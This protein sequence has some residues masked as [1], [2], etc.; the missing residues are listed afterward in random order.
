[1]KNWE[2]I[3]NTNMN[4]EIKMKIWEIIFNTL[5]RLQKLYWLHNKELRNHFENDF[6]YVEIKSHIECQMKNWQLEK[7]HCIDNEELRNHTEYII[8]N[9]QIIFKRKWGIQKSHGIHNEEY[10]SQTEN[11]M[12]KCELTLDRLSRIS[13]FFIPF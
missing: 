12:K 3:L 13:P 11:I 8:K 7:S 9:S 4:S 2:N 5:W 1:M 6:H 10:R